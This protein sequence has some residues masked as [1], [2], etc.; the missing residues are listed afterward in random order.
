MMHVIFST[1][2]LSVAPVFTSGL[3]TPKQDLAPVRMVAY[4]LWAN[5]QI[6]D[7]LSE[8]KPEQMQMLM[9]SSFNTLEKTVIHLWHAEFGWMCTLQKKPWELPDAYFEDHKELLAAFL[10][11]SAAF[12]Q[13]A[14]GL[15]V[16]D[17]QSTRPLGAAAKEV[18]VSDII[19][20]VCNHATYHRG[21]LI[22]MGRQIGLPNPPRTDYIYYVM[23]Q[24]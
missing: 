21:Q 20:H 24:E 16:E 22:T 3:E 4:N 18:P 12:H 13:Y 5:Q 2:L 23:L 15:S 1:W 6:A 8:A 17:L 14:L 19:L 9:E 7:W 10:N 11:T